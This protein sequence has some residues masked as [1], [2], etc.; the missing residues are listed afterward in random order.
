[1]TD[2]IPPALTP[3]EWAQVGS[4]VSRVTAEK[5]VLW[6]IGHRAEGVS[7]IPSL[8][9]MPQRA[10]AE[11]IAL[12]NATLPAGSPYKITRKD[13]D[14][15]DCAASAIRHEYGLDDEDAVDL[16]ALAAKLAA[17]LPPA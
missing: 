11:A 10:P 3:E 15:L 8:A 1:M 17:L 5:D 2:T 12:L 6:F 13:L 4:G 16:D 7:G 14:V 9:V